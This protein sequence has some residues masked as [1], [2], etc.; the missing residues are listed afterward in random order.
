MKY[1]IMLLIVH[2]QQSFKLNKLNLTYE[3]CLISLY[4][5]KNKIINHIQ[6]WM[7][8]TTH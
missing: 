7:G 6:L 1:L 5:P 4:K 2:G 8:L 3:H